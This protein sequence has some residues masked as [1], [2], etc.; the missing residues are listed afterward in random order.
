[1]LK[2]KVYNVVMAGGYG[3]VLDLYKG[4]MQLNIDGD[5]LTRN[6]GAHYLGLEILGFHNFRY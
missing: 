6:G 2:V 3:G 1:M 5:V 4:A